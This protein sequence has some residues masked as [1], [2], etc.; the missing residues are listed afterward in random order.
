LTLLRVEQL[1]HTYT[2]SGQ[3]PV[4]ALHDIDLEVVAGEYVAIVGANGSGKTT[5]ARHLNGLLLPSEGDVWIDGHNT[6]DPTAVRAI[7]STVGMVFQSPLDQIVA[8]VTQEDVAFGPE[9]LGIPAEELPSVVRA[10]LDQVGMWHARHHPPHMLSAG[11]Q[12]RV[13]IAGVLAMNPRC[14]IFDEA[15][16]MLDPGGRRDVLQIMDEL[17]RAGMT[18][19]TITHSMSEAA[20]AERV[21][22]MQ[23]GHIVLDDVPRVVFASE[24]VPPPPPTALARRL[25]EHLPRF[26]ANV[27]TVPEL[28]DAITGVGNGLSHHRG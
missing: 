14:V 11:Q 2:P 18:I 8:T 21:I 26:P 7:R 24:L 3:E 23:G 25:R 6:R 20:R 9:N 28:V 15:T 22:A 1:T 10:A 13:A 19:L 5:L 27:L 17:H 16:T 12:Q 4:P